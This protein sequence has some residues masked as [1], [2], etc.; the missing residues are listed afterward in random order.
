MDF[1]QKFRYSLCQLKKDQTTK[2][3]PARSNSSTKNHDDDEVDE[4]EEINK[5]EFEKSLINNEEENKILGIEI[6]DDIEL[7]VED[8]ID[9][10]EIEEF[11]DEYMEISFK[12]IIRREGKNSAGKCET[13]YQ[14]K[15]YSG[16]INCKIS[17]HLTFRD[18]VRI[19]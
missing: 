6:E 1:S 5:L 19:T 14:T 11:E 9:N 16:C 4:V 10:S 13:I 7:D 17:F 15:E 3:I 8:E 18:D 2:T 12:L